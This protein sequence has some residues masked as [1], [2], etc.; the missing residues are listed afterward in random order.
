VTIAAEGCGQRALMEANSGAS[1]K[2]GC[3]QPSAAIVTTDPTFATWLQLRLQY[4][5]RGEFQA[6]SDT[7]PD[8]LASLEAAP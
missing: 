8:P 5:L 3:P 6:P 7:V 4:A 2:A 1:R